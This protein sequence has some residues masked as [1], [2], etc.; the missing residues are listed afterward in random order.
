MNVLLKLQKIICLWVKI[1]L[2]V[3]IVQKEV[4]IIP[5]SLDRYL[6]NLKIMILLKYYDGIKNF[7][8]YIERSKTIVYKEN[9][10]EKYKHFELIQ[11]LC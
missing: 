8:S 9:Y 6:E 5:N 2:G 4:S 11:Y 10:I 7:D 1:A 3:E